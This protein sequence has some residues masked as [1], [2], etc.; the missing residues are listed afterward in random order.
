MNVRGWARVR[1]RTVLVPKVAHSLMDI[2]NFVHGIRMV[3][4][5][6]A[7]AMEMP[8]M[9]KRRMSVTH[10]RMKGEQWAPFTLAYKMVT[11]FR[12][13]SKGRYPNCTCQEPLQYDNK[14]N[15]CKECPETGIY[16]DC[17]CKNGLFSIRNGRCF[18]CP[19]TSTGIS[20]HISCT[21]W[22]M[23]YSLIWFPSIL[24]VYPECECEQDEHIFSAYINECYI[25]CPEDANGL[26]PTCRCN[27]PSF[28]Y[29][30]KERE[31]TTNE[32]RSCPKE[33][34]GVGPDCLCMRENYI[35]NAYHWRCYNK[36]A[37]FAQSPTSNCPDS[38][39]KWPQCDVSIDRNALLSLIG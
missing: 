34:I 15:E 9:T 7:N 17:N 23:R 39:Q 29:D 5:V 20:Y 18:E 31:C 27:E 2:V 6:I 8:L 1:F 21:T 16:P 4:T 19:I 12:T 14:T 37:T 11:Q 33:S 36:K 22:S 3:H 13:F 35:F 32:G 30:V 10:V 38:S 26:H 28:Y 25:E 24:G